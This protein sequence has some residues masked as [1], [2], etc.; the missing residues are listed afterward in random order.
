[1]VGEVRDPCVMTR[2]IQDLVGSM[3]EVVGDRYGTSSPYVGTSYGGTAYMDA[4]ID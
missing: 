2:K 1:M 3:G 4:R